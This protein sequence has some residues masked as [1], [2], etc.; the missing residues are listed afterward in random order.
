MTAVT[1]FAA[2]TCSHTKRRH[3]D[4]GGVCLVSDCVCVEFE[5]TGAEF[6]PQSAPSEPVTTPPAP[7]PPAPEPDPEPEPDPDPVLEPDPVGDLPPELQD[8]C[9]VIDVDEHTAARVHG[10]VD[11]SPEAA[12]AIATVAAAAGDLLAVC[13]CSHTQHKHYQ[14]AP[15]LVAGCGCDRFRDANNPPPAGACTF[16]GCT[17]R[18]SR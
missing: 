18:A 17:C 4:D 8:G 14:A 16:C 2:C 3:F 9:Y 11:V 13:K 7:P 15:C 1:R 6:D 12:A 5:P 10:P